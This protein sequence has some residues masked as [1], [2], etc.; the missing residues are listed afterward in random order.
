MLSTRSIAISGLGVALALAVGAIVPQQQHASAG[1]M[2]PIIIIATPAIERLAELPPAELPPAELPPAAQVV[3]L[4]PAELPP[5]Q[6]VEL[7][8][9]QV[10]EQPAAQVVE[11]PPAELPPAELPPAQVVELPP[12]QVVE[13]PPA[14]V[15]EQPADQSMIPGTPE[16][17]QALADIHN[18]LPVLVI[19]NEPAA[20]APAGEITDRQRQQSRQR[21]R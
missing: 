5:A 18:S 12:A 15:V 17:N 1:D 6:V 14:Q 8:P 20:A 2:R 10:V 4:P 13:L 19:S 9:A 16:Y 11:L 3:E 7:P 21:T